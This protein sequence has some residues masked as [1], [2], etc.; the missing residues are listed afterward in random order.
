MGLS[1]KPIH[2]ISFSS[3]IDIV[4]NKKAKKRYDRLSIDQQGL[5]S[6]YNLAPSI[7]LP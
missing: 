6:P 5:S 7:S 3:D 1:E 2:Y 4:I